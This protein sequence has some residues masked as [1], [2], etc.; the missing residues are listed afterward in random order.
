VIQNVRRSNSSL[1]L[2]TPVTEKEFHKKLPRYPNDGV[3]LINVKQYNRM[4]ILET[5]ND[6]ALANGQPGAYVVGLGTQQFTVLGAHD[7]W[8]ELT[9]RANIRHFPDMARG[10]MMWFLYNGFI[11]YAGSSKPR[12]LC[13]ARG[14]VDNEHRIQTY[15]P[16]LTNYVSLALRC[17]KE[18]S[19]KDG[20]YGDVDCAGDL[21]IPKTFREFMSIFS[22]IVALTRDTQLLYLR[23]G[24]LKG[25]LTRKTYQ[26]T[27]E[28]LSFPEKSPSCNKD[29]NVINMID[30]FVL[31]N[32][33]W[34][35]RIFHHNPVV[36]NSSLALLKQTKYPINQPNSEPDYQ[37]WKPTISWV[38]SLILPMKTCS[39][40]LL[41][42]RALRLYNVNHLSLNSRMNDSRVVFFVFPVRTK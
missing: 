20:I 27:L 14:N 24:E 40:P 31:H 17:P 25:D 13:S 9:P 29:L 21:P 8:I 35:G 7:R 4:G 28:C 26:Q 18:P 10:F 6:I 36:S 39:N 3:L 32:S 41:S 23:F 34:S 37:L 12:Q 33:S 5:I 1:A 22:R 2:S 38:S 19:Y 30:A 42:L 16:W 11:H 15:T